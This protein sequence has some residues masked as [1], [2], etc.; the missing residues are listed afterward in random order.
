[1]LSL[2]RSIRNII[3]TIEAHP[4]ASMW[5][6]VL[7]AVAYYMLVALQGLDYADEGF[8]LTFYQ[9][10]FSHPEDVEYLFLYYLTGLLGGVWE[11][12]FGGWG[13]Y[14]FRLFFALVSGCNVLV[15]F[16][17]LRRYL[18]VSTV[19][20]GCLALFLY[21]GVDFFVFGKVSSVIYFFIGTVDEEQSRK[22]DVNK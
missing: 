17:I 5:Y 21:V 1:M 11:L 18:P 3:V 22:A 20:L 16:S 6:T 10:I 15:A 4:R 12:L 2:Q 14:G 7:F 13:N 9:Q 19:L 8:S